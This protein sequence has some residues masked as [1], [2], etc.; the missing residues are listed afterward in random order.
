MPALEVQCVEM[1]KKYTDH[2][3]AKKAKK[4][5]GTPP[6]TAS[7]SSQSVTPPASSPA[8]VA[9]PAPV[10]PPSSMALQP[11]AAAGALLVG[12]AMPPSTT[13]NATAAQKQAA[14][15]V[16]ATAA[17]KAAAAA[18]AAQKQAAAKAAAEAQANLKAQ[19]RAKTKAIAELKAQAL[20]AANAQA[21]I[22]AQTV[23]QASTGKK[24]QSAALVVRKLRRQLAAANRA[25]AASLAA[26]NLKYP[27]GQSAGPNGVA[28]VQAANQGQGY[29]AYELD[30]PLFV[31]RNKVEAEIIR[32]RADA[33][34][35][36]AYDVLERVVEMTSNK[37]SARANVFVRTV[38]SMVG[39]NP[40][41]CIVSQPFFLYL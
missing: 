6:S 29:R 10:T 41:G 12:E 37:N 18:T 39:D 9:P 30:P 36:G 11:S 31:P 24:K 13:M 27:T 26:Q 33:G 34:D 8:P 3:R 25:H 23:C 2:L 38:R 4:A 16:A 17:A 32:V 35:R 7:T 14:A 21:T 5:R 1:G 15:K 28:E 22:Q 40:A 19:A 20:A